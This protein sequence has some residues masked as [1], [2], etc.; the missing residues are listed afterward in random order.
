[1]KIEYLA[2]HIDR[3]REVAAL[4]Q[5]EW[6]SPQ[7]GDSIDGRAQTLAVCCQRGAIPVGV[8]AF[9]QNQLCGFALLVLQDFELRPDLS[10][11]LAGVFVRPQHRQRGIGSALV[12]RIEYEA[13]T[14]GVNTVYL[15]TAQSRT[16]YARLGRQAIEQCL[17]NDRHFT[18]MAKALN[19]S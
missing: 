11:W 2:D 16:L 15:Y 6:P 10:P 17:H 14:L 19:F 18:V 8:I 7:L 4:H 1:M 12:T 13:Q 9:D 3:L 5:E